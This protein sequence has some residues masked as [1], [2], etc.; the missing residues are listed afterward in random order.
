[1][2]FC[3]VYARAC[4]CLCA[5]CFPV[6]R[7]GRAMPVCA[8][9]PFVRCLSV[10]VPGGCECSVCNVMPVCVSSVYMSFRA[11]IMW[12]ILSLF[13]ALLCVRQH[14][15]LRMFCSAHLAVCLLRCVCPLS[16]LSAFHVSLPSM[17]VLPVCPVSLPGSSPCSSALVPVCPSLPRHPAMPSALLS[18]LCDLPCPSAP[19]R[20]SAF[21]FSSSA[22]VSVCLSDIV[23]LLLAFACQSLS[24]VLLPLHVYPGL[25]G[26]S[27]VWVV[28]VFGAFCTFTMQSLEQ[29]P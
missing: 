20:L 16:M 17:S 24:L 25:C 14:M 6:Y 10:C 18:R 22:S 28:S 12:P 4:V 13:F 9:T 8:C 3:R 26:V 21:S 23:C 2:S 1:M 7:T 27:L 11:H 15:C 29:V 19:L 5:I